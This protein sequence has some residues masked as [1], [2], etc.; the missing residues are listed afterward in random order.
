[1]THIRVGVD[2]G[3]TFTDLVLEDDDGTQHSRAKV[4][5]TPSEPTTAVIAGL[6]RLIS[7]TPGVEVADLAA[8]VHGTTVATNA[9]IQHGW[10]RTGLITSQ[11]FKDIIEI[12]RQ[13]RPDVYDLR[14]PKPAAIVPRDLRLEVPERVRADG[15]VS[16]A[17]DEDAVRAAV[18]RLVAA[19]VQAIAVCF[20]HSYAHPAHERR[21]VEIIGEEAPDLYVT[22]SSDVA[23][24]FREF[25]RVST[26]MANAALGPVMRQ[27]LTALTTETKS[28][29]LGVEP[30]VMQSNGGIA[31]PAATARHPV[32]TLVSGPTAGVIGA[33]DAATRSGLANLVTFDVGG[34]STDVCLV[35]DG[36]PVITVEKSIAGYPLRGSMVDVHSIGA[37]GG[38]IAWVDEGGFLQ[39]GPQS[40][41]AVPGPAC[42]GG[43][44]TRPTVTDANLVLGRLGDGLLGGRMTLDRE[45]A[46]RATLTHVGAS[47]DVDV[48]EA[49]H[50]IIRVANANMARAIRLVSVERGHDPRRFALVAF[51][52]AGP[53]HMAEVGREVGF[54]TAL[55][56]GAPGLLSACGL[57]SS[58]IRADFARTYPFGVHDGDMDEIEAVFGELCE[59]ASRWLEREAPD[60]PPQITRALDLRYVGQSF[61]I[62]VPISNDRLS[63]A[64]RG[65]IMDRFFGEYR[66]LY[67]SARE[68]PIEA[69]TVR[70]SARAATPASRPRPEADGTSPASNGAA[71]TSRPVFFASSGFV[72]TPVYSRGELGAAGRLDG[73]AIIEQDDTTAVIP[74]GSTIEWNESGNIVVEIG[75]SGAPA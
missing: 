22:A 47:L 26:T 37:G 17:L 57:L 2:V 66:R 4:P 52:G 35:E 1:M 62:T 24:E 54:R 27:Y 64:S 20:L 58:P 18:H 48:V 23:A 74:P 19:G 3:G 51:G 36:E 56:P 75:A 16:V 8:L 41:G 43:G 30:T 31:S 38:S 60:L 53:L 44:G 6:E 33:V 11:G 13:Q 14:V 15:S 69:V 59:R 9:V 21:A 25:P 63:E 73:P 39:V 61:E 34:T 5:S 70:V 72:S 67:R 68:A 55:I 7:E 49:A 46:E 10:A 50:A 45:A 42:Y 29:G 32:Q 12:R 71:A 40:A 65:E 28:L